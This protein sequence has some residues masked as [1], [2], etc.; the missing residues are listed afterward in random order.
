MS[1]IKGDLKIPND[2]S[3]YCR[4][5]DEVATVGFISKKNGMCILRDA[6]K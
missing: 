2:T 6:K 4:T 5:L 3:I 1:E